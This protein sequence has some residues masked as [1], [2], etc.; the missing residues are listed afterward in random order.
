M[1]IFANP[2]SNLVLGSTY[3]FMGVV[4]V[5]VTRAVLTI[6]W[7]WCM[8]VYSGQYLP[9]HGG[10]AC[11]CNQGS[12]YHFMGVVHVGVVGGCRVVG[13]ARQHG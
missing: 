4:H 7:G 13:A 12:T 1:N 9:F 10:G 8:L 2:R 11:W 3:H 5:G 6:S